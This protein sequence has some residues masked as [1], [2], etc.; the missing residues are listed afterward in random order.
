[1]RVRASVDGIEAQIVPMGEEPRRSC[2]PGSGSAA[3]PDDVIEQ[4]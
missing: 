2:L 3:D 1:V 4:R